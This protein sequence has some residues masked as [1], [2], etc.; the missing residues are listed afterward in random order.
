MSV[1]WCAI[2]TAS[3]LRPFA[4]SV[5]GES[6]TATVCP[7]SARCPVRESSLTISNPFAATAGQ[8]K[9]YKVH[10]VFLTAPGSVHAFPGRAAL[11]QRRSDE[12]LSVSDEPLALG[13]GAG[14]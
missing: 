3:E 2:L 11:R 5:L 10:V 12:R 13:E 14:H 6:A 4:L 9:R 8:E 1:D 7:P